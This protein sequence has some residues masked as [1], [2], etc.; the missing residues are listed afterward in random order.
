MDILSALGS[1]SGLNTSEIISGLV[2]AERDPKTELLSKRR[3][4]A[5]TKISALGQVRATVGA[6]S[7]ALRS[8][9][10]SGALGVLPQLSRT[11][12]ATAT[13][14]SSK[15]RP[16]NL[17]FSV[18]ALAAPQKLVSRAFGPGESG[19]LGTGKITIDLGRFTY[20]SEG[21]PSAF[22]GALPPK[23]LTLDIR[24]SDQT[25]DAIA[26]KINAAGIG[27]TA[28]LLRDGDTT[29]LIMKGPEGAE[30]GFKI[31]VEPDD[32]ASALADLS[33]DVGAG[34]MT[35]TQA[36]KDARL[37][38]EGVEITRSSNRIDDLVTGVQ[39]DLIKAEPGETINLAAAYDTAELSTAVGNFTAAYNELVG[40]LNELTARPTG[41]SEGGALN[42]SREVRELQSQLSAL[43]T[44][45]LGTG[46]NAVR[47]AD[48]GVKS[49]R[50]GTLSLDNEALQTVVSQTP[51]VLSTLFG[52]SAS[53]SAGGIA[54]DSDVSGIPAGEYELSDVVP[55]TRGTLRGTSQPNAF[56]MPLTID[57]SNRN[58]RV[59][60]DGVGSLTI[61]LDEGTYTSYADFAA[62][63]DRAIA[64]D[65]LLAN[66][67]AGGS[68][69]VENDSLVFTSNSKGVSS[70]FAITEM[71]PALS[72][73]LGLDTATAQQ[74]TAASGK[75]NGRDL[76]SF[77]D[78]L[79]VK[80]G[81]AGAG[82][83]FTATAAIASA[84]FEVSHGLSTQLARIAEQAASADG[85]IGS[86]L[87]ALNN[88][89]LRIGEDE[90]KLE[91]RMVSY[92]ARLKAQF[93]AMEAAVAGFKS[94]Q[95]F[96][97]QQ[98]KMWTSSEN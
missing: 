74:G 38:V 32:P 26:A 51:E 22:E 17:S 77:G 66:F 84:T 79:M 53:F 24:S 78:S 64:R 41:S 23:S 73:R 45:R 5:D 19:S 9:Q 95:D 96:L 30:N 27:L 14:V 42:G 13:I 58:I 4:A 71:D 1:G 49:N 82:M 3:E 40:L 8:L 90:E 10:S 93:G 89:Q 65:S 62:M 75:L 98:I 59:R 81:D 52:D 72:A 29:R 44:T 15:A 55:A 54:L 48:I 56:D 63:M 57:S 35:Q 6:F 11:D 83:K 47:L 43:T 18:E 33:F 92:E 46:S 28:S 12:L 68:V 70:S 67:G 85:G 25:L 97:D 86:R 39:I 31:S 2:A 20:D 91:A 88:E 87:A 80:S 37:L 60:V 94:T 50:D 76:L 16:A 61:A 36:A 21:L 7:D 34:A 69:A